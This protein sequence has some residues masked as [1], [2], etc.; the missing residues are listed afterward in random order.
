MVSDFHH[1]RPHELTWRNRINIAAVFT[2]LFV[3]MIFSHA[4]GLG[5]AVVTAILGVSGYLTAKPSSFRNIPLWFFALA[6][7]CFWAALSS[8]WSPYEDTKT[9]SNPIKLILVL[10]LYPGA[11]LS[12]RSAGAHD[13]NVL[14]HMLMA[15]AI[16]ALG[17][18]LID[19]MSGYGITY[20]MDPPNPGEDIVRKGGDIE[21]NLGH[22]ISVLA[23]LMPVVMTVMRRQLSLG[24][25][26]AATFGV[27]VAI[28]ALLGNLIVGVMAVLAG[29][30]AMY[31][32]RLKPM[33]TLRLITWFAIASIL[34]APLLGFLA[35]QASPEFKA[36]LPFSWEHRIEM[37]AYTAQRIMESPI[38]GHGF[39]AVRTFDATFSSRGV[40]NWAI[41]S[42]H[43]HNAGLH[44]WAETGLIGVALA[45]VAILTMGISI[46]YFCRNSHLR[47]MAAAGAMT[48]GI[49]LS[50]VTYG[51]WQEWWW[52]TLFFVSGTLY[53]LPKRF[54]IP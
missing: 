45:C 3:V 53:L 43:P 23:L 17:V 20:L 48:V 16:L 4:G 47:T 1:A 37:W 40:E 26:L 9:L 25:F 6:L 15:M 41:V 36:Q 7:F 21:M 10:V 51:V 42:L 31:M 46:E 29:L 30:F 38:W 12:F 35:A 24:W 28:A 5:I 11:L 34:L 13:R 14:R 32:A 54:P 49:V 18:L 52:A 8:F 19:L 22:H 50:G 39:D 44:I 2:A 27:F 33:K